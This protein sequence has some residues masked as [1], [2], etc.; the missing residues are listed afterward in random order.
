MANIFK[1]AVVQSQPLK[2]L[3]ANLNQIQQLLIEASRQ[4]E[5]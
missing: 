1:V 5:A 3:E 4:G 2:K